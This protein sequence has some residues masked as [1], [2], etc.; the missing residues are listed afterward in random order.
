MARKTK[1]KTQEATLIRANETLGGARRDL[2]QATK[3][4][5]NQTRSAMAR[6]DAASKTAMA[7]RKVSNPT[8]G[9]KT[10]MSGGKSAKPMSLSA[11]AGR[12]ASGVSGRVAVDSFVQR[13]VNCNTAE[14]AWKL[15]M[16][17][18]E[19]ASRGPGTTAR[20]TV[21][22]TYYSSTTF[23]TVPF[24]SVALAPA[25]AAS[26]MVDQ[27]GTMAIVIAP[28]QAAALTVSGFTRTAGFPYAQGTMSP[29]FVCGG[30]Y[31]MTGATYSTGP[32]GSAPT[33]QALFVATPSTLGTTP[34]LPTTVT[35]LNPFN[36]AIPTEKVTVSNGG[37]NYDYVPF[38]FLGVRSTLECVSS[39]AGTGAA[40]GYCLAGD[41][42]D[43]MQE[44]ERGWSTSVNNIEVVVNQD[45]ELDVVDVVEYD[46]VDLSD[47]Q[48]N[49]G[50][51]FQRV[52]ECG[53]LMAGNVYETVALPVNT[54]FWNYHNSGNMFNPDKV[55][56]S[57]STTG[58]FTSNI[59][60]LSMRFRPTSMFMLRG[61]VAGNTFRV[62][63][64]MAIEVQVDFDSPIGFLYNQARFAD[65]FTPKL[66]HIR[67][68]RVAGLLGENLSGFVKDEPAA[69]QVFVGRATGTL[70]LG[71]VP[72]STSPSAGAVGS[73][74]RRAMQTEGVKEVYNYLKTGVGK[75][76][77]FALD[78]PSL[79]AK[80]IGYLATL[81]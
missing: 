36:S 67:A 27:S 44:G 20:P 6:D 78:N 48:L 72:P 75:A 61:I 17:D 70:A 45:V 35:P 41:F 71:T 33:L 60:G 50:T 59:G 13:E 22:L 76:A 9:R 16:F 62:G 23:T 63:T 5:L 1:A 37:S 2:Q 25:T 52:T 64:T 3:L 49:Y 7:K 15:G 73:T 32:A 55:F 28:M 24:S 43:Y 21:V 69:K 39:V 53:P 66:Q 68:V 30:N 19:F 56:V 31:D 57:S 46:T 29:G 8:P 18:P 40:Q 42:S 11:S 47:Y 10:K 54:H 80:G 26:F 74:S 12:G 14:C 81:V 34:N 79:V 77:R 51:G 65:D 38:R 4:I 58:S